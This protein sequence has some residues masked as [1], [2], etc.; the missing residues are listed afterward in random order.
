MDG[1]ATIPLARIAADPQGA[2]TVIAALRWIVDQV[3]AVG[4]RSRSSG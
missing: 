3:K 1:W 4:T 2:G